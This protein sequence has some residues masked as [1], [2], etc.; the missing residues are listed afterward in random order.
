MLEKGEFP[1]WND[2]SIMASMYLL[3]IAG[4][5]FEADAITCRNCAAPSSPGG[6]ER[7]FLARLLAMVDSWWW[8]FMSMVL[9]LGAKGTLAV[10]RS[11]RAPKNIPSSPSDV[12]ESNNDISRYG[13]QPPSSLPATP[14]LRSNPPPHHHSQPRSLPID[15]LPP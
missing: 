10:S 12:G 6:G 13:S 15:F 9:S 11:L 14:Y 3:C 4:T 5:R 7:T 2:L 8:I 1:R